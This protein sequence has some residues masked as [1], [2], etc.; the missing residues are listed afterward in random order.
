MLSFGS[1][2]LQTPRAEDTVPVLQLLDNS[3]WRPINWQQKIN[4]EAKELLLE[5]NVLQQ[6][7]QKL[8]RAFPRTCSARSHGSVLNLS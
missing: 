7:E 2:S 5:S 3:C 6:V 4:E 1:S 8:A